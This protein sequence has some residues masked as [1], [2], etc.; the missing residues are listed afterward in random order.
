[1]RALL[2]LPK[3]DQL[4]VH[5]WTGGLPGELQSGHISGLAAPVGSTIAP[6]G[7][8]TRVDPYGGPFYGCDLVDKVHL[9]CAFSRGKCTILS[10]NAAGRFDF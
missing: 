5:G 1:M 6:G 8:A 3:D 10:L 7:V 9:V 4:L 2:A